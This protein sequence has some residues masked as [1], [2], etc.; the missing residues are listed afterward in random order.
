MAMEERV[1]ER[2]I[3]IK[4]VSEEQKKSRI[5]Q[6]FSAIQWRRKYLP[7]RRNVTPMP[8]SRDISWWRS[9]YR[10]RLDGRW[11]S[12]SQT[13]YRFYTAEEVLDIFSRLSGV[14]RQENGGEKL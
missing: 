3:I 8:P 13:K 12:D 6:I 9:H 5:L 1:P 7:G 10:L 11:M 14:V 2:T 4:C